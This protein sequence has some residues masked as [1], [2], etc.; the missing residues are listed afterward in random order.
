MGAE[1]MQHDEWRPL[2]IPMLPAN[3]TA[4][5]GVMSS[6][7]SQDRAKAE[8]DALEM[9]EGKGYAQSSR[10]SRH[11]ARLTVTSRSSRR[12]TIP[13]VSCG[14]GCQTRTTR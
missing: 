1:Q 2:L 12:I 11:T 13:I 8:R 7:S 9:M 10:S 4:A 3:E 5:T 6:T 14:I